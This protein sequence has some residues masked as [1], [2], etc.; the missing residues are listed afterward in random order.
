MNDKDEIIIS[1]E[2]GLNVNV[3]YPGLI[4]NDVEGAERFSVNSFPPLHLDL[5]YERAQNFE[6]L[7]LIPCK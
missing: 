1:E 3:I 5:M 7:N 2:P 6:N 4:N